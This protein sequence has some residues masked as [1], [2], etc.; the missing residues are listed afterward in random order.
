MRPGISRQGGIS[1]PLRIPGTKNAIRPNRG[2][3][4]PFT[5]KISAGEGPHEGQRVAKEHRRK[6]GKQRHSH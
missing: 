4:S 3:P 1:P 6:A 2:T 5:H